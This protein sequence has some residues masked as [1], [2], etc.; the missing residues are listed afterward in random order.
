MSAQL[1]MLLWAAA[2]I[3]C[4]PLASALAQG[5]AM[6]IEPIDVIVV[7][8]QPI[9]RFYPNEFDPFHPKDLI[10]NVVVTELDSP[11]SIGTLFWSYDWIDLTG[12]IVTT[13]PRDITLPGGAS[14]PI[15][16]TFRIPF[17]PQQVSL[18]FHSDGMFHVQGTF[19]HICIPEPSS[20]LLLGFGAVALLTCRQVRR[21][22]QAPS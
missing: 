1:R 9:D 14:V 5:P 15:V 20:G 12:G 3:G 10:L 4:L 7:G 19:T 6:A 16:D 18:H 21:R 13:P 17:C 22:K 11:T 8:S 2:A